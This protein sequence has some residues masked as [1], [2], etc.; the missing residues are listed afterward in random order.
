M[1]I[2]QARDLRVTNRISKKD[3]AK[4]LGLSYAYVDMLDCQRYVGSAAE[5]WAVPYVEAVTKLIQEKNTK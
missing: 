2:K 1:D 3:V 5:K 4:E